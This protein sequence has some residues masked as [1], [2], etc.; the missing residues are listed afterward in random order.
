M[1]GKQPGN[2]IINRVKNL[3]IIGWRPTTKPPK[4]FIG[5]RLRE[6]RKERRWTQQRLADLLGITQGHLSQ[7]ER[8]KREL[9]ARQ[10]LTILNHFNV[11]IDYFSPEPPPTGSQIQNALARHGAGHLAESADI[12]P[13]ERLKRATDTIRETLVSA[14]SSRQIAAVAPVLVNHAGQFNLTRL[15]NEFAA[16]GLENRLGWAIDCTLEAIRLQSEQV[17]QRELRLKYRRAALIIESFFAPWRISP[18]PTTDPRDP[19]QYDVL[20]PEITSRETLD[21]V[22]KNLSPIAQ[23]WK[24]ATGIEVDDFGRALR[25]AYGTD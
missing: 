9:S 22:I 18:G 16:L 2:A 6:L 23:K 17:L 11:P 4:T 8:G 25:G 5:A 24:I 14:D 15:R 1:G 20:D 7:L 19:P 10:L 12:F 3:P 21:Q 13:T